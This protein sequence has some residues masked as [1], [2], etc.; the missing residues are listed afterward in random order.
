[1]SGTQAFICTAHVNAEAIC[2]VCGEDL[3]YTAVNSTW[4]DLTIIVEPCAKCLEK[5]RDEAETTGGEQ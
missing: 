4:G 5:A 1:M 3:E 2:K